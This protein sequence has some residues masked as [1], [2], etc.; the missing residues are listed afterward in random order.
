MSWVVRPTVEA[1]QNLEE[2]HAYIQ[3]RLKTIR[4]RN[5]QK[6]GRTN[7]ES[8]PLPRPLSLAPP[9]LQRRTVAFPRYPRS[10]RGQLPH[11]LP[12]Q[13]MMSRYMDDTI[14]KKLYAGWRYG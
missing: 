12:P 9:Y 13:N 11:L 10:P 1:E 14:F 7:C 5:C 6:A 3:D 8:I 4:T 2:I